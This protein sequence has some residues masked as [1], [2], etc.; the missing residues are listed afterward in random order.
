MC[1]LPGD[2]NNDNLPPAHVCENPGGVPLG[3]VCKW[4]SYQCI[5]AEPTISACPN[6]KSATTQSPP[7]CTGGGPINFASGNTFVNQTDVSIPGLGGGLALSRT[8]NSIL[9]AAA[10]G[11]TSG[12]FGLH[13][14]S[15]FEERIVLGS[16]GLFKFFLGNGDVWSFGF[17]DF[18]PDPST[19]RYQTAAPSNGTTSLFLGGSTWTITYQDGGSKNFDDATGTLRSIID[20]NGNATVLYY[21]GANRLTSIT[22]PASRHL[23]FSYGSG[24]A[25]YLVTSVTSD[26]G[27][28]LSYSYDNQGRLT[29]VTKPDATTVSFEYNEQSLIT[30]VKDSDNKVLESHTYD[31]QG[32]GLT[33]SRA[34][35]VEAI[36][37]SYQKPAPPTGP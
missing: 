23:Y 11:S 3:M 7:V 14:R 30:A 37:V 5:A 18:G 1:L 20:R 13:W 28:S 34:N 26:F 22:D 27:I 33:S 19:Y 29:S 25:S 2:C 32:R 21:D 35:G 15:N 4:K 31:S 36:S 16:D 12:M 24:A 6:P 17:S 10:A 8:W 9:P